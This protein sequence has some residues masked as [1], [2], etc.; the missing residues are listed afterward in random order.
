[1]PDSTTYVPNHAVIGSDVSDDNPIVRVYNKTGRTFVYGKYRVAPN[2]F[3]DAP[4][5]VAEFWLK[6]FPDQVIGNEIA[7]RELGGATARLAEAHAKIKALETENAALKAVPMG[8]RAQTQ[9]N[10][11]LARVKELEAEVETLTAPSEAKAGAG[12]I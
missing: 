1:M 4:A 12:A 8:D 10:Q 5:S 3:G 11:L 6:T 9:V 7:A 2:S